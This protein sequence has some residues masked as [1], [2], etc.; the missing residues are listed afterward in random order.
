M[1]NFNRY[2]LKKRFNRASLTPRGSMNKTE[3]AFSEVLQLRLK[4][5]EIHSWMYE[6]QSFKIGT[7]CRYTPDFMVVMPDGELVAYEVKGFMRDDALVKLKSFK[8]QFGYTTYLVRLVKKQWQITE[9][10]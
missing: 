7:D 8:D 1:S 6:R 9:V 4:A 2:A 10:K 5:G 3:Q